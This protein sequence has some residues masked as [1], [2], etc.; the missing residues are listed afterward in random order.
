MSCY[1][2]HRL[3]WHWPNPER[4][5][6]DRFLGPPSFGTY[7]PFSIGPHTCLGKSLAEVQM[8]LSMARVFHKLDLELEPP[9]YVL[10]TKSAPTP[11]PAMDFKVRV[12]GYRH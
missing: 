3:P 12:K 7:L 10:K 11:G 5:D 2:Q 6:P 8:A 9:D 1:V 4:F